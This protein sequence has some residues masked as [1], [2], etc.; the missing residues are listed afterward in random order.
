MVNTLSKCI[1]AQNYMCTGKLIENTGLWGKRKNQC[2]V[3]IAASTLYCRCVFVLKSAAGT[4]IA[5]QPCQ[6]TIQLWAF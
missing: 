6:K 1:M 3:L 4:M 5:M 2:S